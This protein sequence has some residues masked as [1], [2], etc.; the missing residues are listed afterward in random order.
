MVAKAP[1]I[2]YNPKPKTDCP[3]SCLHIDFAGS[4]KGSY[5]LIIVD[6]FSKWPEILRSF[7]LYDPLLQLLGRIWQA[8]SPLG[9]SVRCASALENSSSLRGLSPPGFYP[10]RSGWVYCLA[11]KAPLIR[12]MPTG[13]KVF[14]AM[15][16]T[17]ALYPATGPTLK[18]PC[19]TFVWWWDGWLIPEI[20]RC[21]KPTTGVVIGWKYTK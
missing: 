1:P 11:L 8:G 21:K 7:F 19:A 3:W 16:D 6:S 18:R 14:L 4:L 13:L 9:G 2:K 17:C 10:L 20:L 15:P 5:Y 12:G